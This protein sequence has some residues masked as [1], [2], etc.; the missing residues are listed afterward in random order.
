MHTEEWEASVPAEASRCL[1]EAARA[2]SGASELTALPGW[3]VA[4]TR[5]LQCGRSQGGWLSLPG[6]HPLEPC[7]G[8]RSLCKT[9]SGSLRCA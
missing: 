5:G 8:A 6:A 1:Q 3:H 9:Q 7:P 2:P 4:G